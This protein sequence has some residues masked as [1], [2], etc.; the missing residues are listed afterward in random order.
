VAG[1]AYLL[2][3]NAYP[4]YDYAFALSSAQDILHGRTTGYDVAIYSPVPHA[5]TMGIS[6][7]TVPLGGATLP[8]FVIVALLAL[9]LLVASVLRIGTLLGGPAVGA[10]AAVLV[11]TNPPLFELGVR[12]Y[13]DV[14]FASLVL[15]AL[16]L[17]LHRPRRGWPVLGVLTLAGLLRPEGWGLAAAYWLYLFPAR[18]WRER[19]ALACLVALAPLLWSAMDVGLTGDPLHSIR[20]TE[21]Y[22][23]RAHRLLTVD[24]L[25]IALTAVS[26][27]VILLGAI[28]GAVLAWR[29]DR[30]RTA[31]VLAVGLGTFALTV[32]PAITGSTPVLRRYLL[33]PGSLASVL[34]AF[35]CVGW[36]GRA[37]E[38]RRGSGAMGGRGAKRGRSAAVVAWA[39]AGVALLAVAV[40]LGADGRVRSWNADRRAQRARVSALEDLRRWAGSGTARVY[41]RD[42][43]CHPI[44]TPGYSFRPYLR[45]WTDVP[46]RSVSF[47]LA[48]FT[49]N[50]RLLLLPTAAA[51][52]ERTMLGGLGRAS[53]AAIIADPRFARGYRRVAGNRRWDLYADAACRRAVGRPRTPDG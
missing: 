43:A 27:T 47:D 15:A 3:G 52:Y 31:L 16:A 40:A 51:G 37:R 18:S 33:V 6:L 36:V 13:G 35:A 30:R 19:I 5:L 41:L 44:R 17:E 28:P 26:S 42:P 53:R 10:L 2:E 4:S 14:W 1:L 48:D 38:A 20:H 50:G 9:G 7:L 22:T 23:A 24:S 45:L 25:R 8:V 11:F 21:T 49:P 12:T 29:A 46:P 39:V 34:F 32:A